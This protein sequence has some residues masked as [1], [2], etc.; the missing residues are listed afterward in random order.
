MFG[1][2]NSHYCYSLKRKSVL[3]KFVCDILVICCLDRHTVRDFVIA[4]MV[5]FGIYCNKC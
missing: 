5:W 4:A 3:D 1:Q 2:L